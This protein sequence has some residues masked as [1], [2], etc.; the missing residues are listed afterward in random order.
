MSTAVKIRNVTQQLK[1]VEM[2]KCANPIV[3]SMLGLNLS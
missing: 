3:R 2:H 1:H